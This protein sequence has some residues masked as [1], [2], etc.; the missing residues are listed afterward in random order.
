M[1]FTLWEFTPLEG[2]GRGGDCP[3]SI[4]YPQLGLKIHSMK[5]LRILPALILFLSINALQAQVIPGYQGKRLLVEF[6]FNFSPAFVGPTKN[7][8]SII[9]DGDAL[10]INARYEFGASYAIGRRLSA[11][12]EYNN[13]TTAYRD[14]LIYQNEQYNTL[15]EVKASTFGIG[16]DITSKKPGKWGL[17]PLGPSFGFSIA[18]GRAKTAI[19]KFRNTGEVPA[20]TAMAIKKTM[21]FE[22]DNYYV[23]G[24]RLFNR[25]VIW[26]KVTLNYGVNTGLALGIGS[27][28]ESVD[29][30]D[31]R[32]GRI[33]YH[34]LFNFNIGVGYLIY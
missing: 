29:I 6:N 34:Y 26:D 17:A 11:R 8:K 15:N 25:Q 19:S 27:S 23:A 18:T 22:K 31:V 4:D 32:V 28:P 1:I 10:A 24:F 2:G 3:G 21:T 12:I 9:R 16:L 30:V 14:D 5:T 20:S 33:V 13:L 7:D